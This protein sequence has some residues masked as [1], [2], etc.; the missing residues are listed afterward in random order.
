MLTDNAGGAR[1]A[2]S[3][4]I[5]R[6]H[7]RI[8]FLGDR[9]DLHTATERLRGYR[10]GAR[11]PRHPRARPSLIRGAHHDAYAVT[12][13]LLLAEDPP[14]ALFTSQ[15]LITI[16]AVRAIHDLGLQRDGRARRLRR[17]RARPTSSSPG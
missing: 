8:A 13:E 11:P 12:R 6:G 4:L 9:P 10:D 5:D 2:V 1:A 16:D 7:R 3:H 14:T 15:N 17:R